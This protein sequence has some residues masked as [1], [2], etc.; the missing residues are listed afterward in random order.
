MPVVS[1]TR[2]HLRSLWFFA[3]FTI[4]ALGSSRQAK[5]SRGFKAGWIGNESTRGFWTVTVWED[6][7]A[8]RAF[9]NS[10]VHM[11]AMPRLLRWCDE[12]S[13]VHWEQQDST[14]PDTEQAYA[15]LKEGGR[16]SKVAY[17]SSS[18]V[19]GQRVSEK[20]PRRG[21]LLAPLR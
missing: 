4:R 13:F 19:A 6:T 5:R 15:R 1:V 8:M 12:A 14:A 9:R 16:T 3:P 2:L 18:Q 7:T 11:R 17:P 21:Q 20:R 10:G